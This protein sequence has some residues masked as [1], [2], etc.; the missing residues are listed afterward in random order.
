MPSIV[1][2]LKAKRALHK[3][4]SKNQL[5]RREVPPKIGNLL[6]SCGADFDYEYYRANF[7]TRRKEY[8]SFF[9]DKI[10]TRVGQY[11]I[12]ATFIITLIKCISEIRWPTLQAK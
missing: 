6:I 4:N 2:C 8:S 7:E 3:L 11:L 1:L 9:S 10:Y 12:I 5:R